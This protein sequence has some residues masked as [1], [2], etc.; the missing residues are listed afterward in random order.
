MMFCGEWQKTAFCAKNPSRRG[1]VRVPIDAEMPE[2]RSLAV[3]WVGGRPS[4]PRGL[5]WRR[6]W[7]G[8]GGEAGTLN[9]KC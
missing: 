5:Q 8:V 6:S 7:G 2:P 4:P 1:T 9:D 3:V